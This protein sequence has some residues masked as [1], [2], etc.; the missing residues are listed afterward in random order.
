[1]ANEYDHIFLNNAARPEPF[2]SFGSGGGGATLPTR[3]RVTH[4]E[5]LIRRFEAIRN[6]ED[7]DRS[8][9]TARSIPTRSGTYLEF[10]SE[11]GYELLT[12]SLDSPSKGIRLLCVHKPLE[13]AG[14]TQ[15]IVYVPHGQERY[16][17]QKVEEYGDS[18]KDLV[19]GSPKNAPLV[20]SIADAKLALM[21]SLWLPEERSRIPQS[22]A[23]WCEAWI[24]IEEQFDFEIQLQQFQRISAA[25][26]I[27]FKTDM[28]RFPE[29]VVLLILADQ[30]MLTELFMQ[31]DQLA[32]LRVAQEVAGYW[33]RELRPSEQRQW[34]ENL[35]ERINWQPTNVKVCILDSGVNNGHPLLSPFLADAD[36]LT[37]N[38]NW[39]TADVSAISGRGGHGTLM[40]GLGAFGDLQ[41]ALE[42][43]DT[44]EVKHRLCSVKIL[45]RT[46]NSPKELW[47][48]YTSQAV[49]RAEEANPEH[50][51][52]FCL[53]VT[54]DADIDRGRPS[55]WSAEVDNI[56]F[57]NLGI[58][59]LFLISGGNITDQDF[60]SGY[61][62]KNREWSVQN[63]AQAWNALTVGAY[64]EKNRIQ[65]RGFENA[66]PVAPMGGL[67][68]HSATSNLWE[69]RK[70][71]I[72]PEIVFE[73]GNVFKRHTEGGEIVDQHEDLQVL[74]TAKNLTERLFDAFGG[75]S[76]ATAKAAWF[77]AQI[78]TRYPEA[79]PETIRALMVHSADW[80]EQMLLQFPDIGTPRNNIYEL[81]RTFGYGVPNLQRALNST[82]R[83]FSFVAEE[84]IQPFRRE[85]GK[86]ASMHEMHLFQLPWPKEILLGLGE[87]SVKLK[88]TLSYFVEPG[89][90]E[91]GWK[92]RYRYPSFALRFEVN[93][94]GD[95]ESEFKRRINAR[96]TSVEEGRIT[97]ADN[98][99]WKIGI[100]NRN[101]GSIHSDCWEGTAADFADCNMIAVYPVIGWWR[102]REHLRKYDSTARYSLIVS[103]ETEIEQVELYSAVQSLIA[104][105]TPIEV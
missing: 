67:S 89:P 86:K 18:G 92:D 103:L 52:I 26:G 8:N 44:V 3:E 29:R 54:T 100:D 59:R 15:A 4:S 16:F 105:S 57:G 85:S 45:P 99:R 1:M 101:L 97:G 69:K 63:P 24:R 19:S 43:L 77:A 56:A 33:M 21:E 55:S 35:L 34:A 9:R 46:G 95:S 102:E 58:R 62:E 13:G 50:L 93:H 40:A 14:L 36:C 80:T 73:G 51:C 5:H 6:Q 27:E 65:E 104:T 79:W 39:G 64:T 37:I 49:A 47:G 20:S 38:P 87:T 91:V 60:W 42:S 12:K 11:V 30:A 76:P 70:W 48:N 74:S 94:V 83:A 23:M 17:L 61:P 82:E 7:A 31:S 98:S 28:I 81:L 90:G 25:V 53:A 71:P 66:M 10:E 96:A 41:A 84:E 78:A 68:P 32:E 22:S 88:V 2:T 72:K 75:T